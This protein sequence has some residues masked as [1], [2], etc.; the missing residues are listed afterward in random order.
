MHVEIGYCQQ[1]VLYFRRWIDTV[2]IASLG[3]STLVS[4]KDSLN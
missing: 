4:A 1:C 2:V 3:L